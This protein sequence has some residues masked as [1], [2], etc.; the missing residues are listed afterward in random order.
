MVYSPMYYFLTT[1]F[2]LL[3]GLVGFFLLELERLGLPVRLFLP[4]DRAEEPRLCASKQQMWQTETSRHGC[5]V[6]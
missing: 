4:G 3:F 6:A 2:L 5:T 1:L